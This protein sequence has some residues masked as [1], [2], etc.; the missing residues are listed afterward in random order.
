[1]KG[2][3]ET[4]PRASVTYAQ[5]WALIPSFI[6]NPPLT[7]NLIPPRFHVKERFFGFL[8]LKNPCFSREIEGKAA[9]YSQ[10]VL[11][12]K[13]HKPPLKLKKSPLVFATRGVFDR[14]DSVFELCIFG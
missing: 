8:K 6:H 13:K 12:F 4:N 3:L 2:G 7:G 1:M 14:A 5:K 10:V 11:F 9:R